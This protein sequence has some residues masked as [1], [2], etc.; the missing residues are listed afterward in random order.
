MVFSIKF[1]V[2][3]HLTMDAQRA[4]TSV[5]KY[6]TVSIRFTTIFKG[7]KLNKMLNDNKLMSYLPIH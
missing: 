3:T 4:T 1:L 7:K 2:L 5:I 6:T